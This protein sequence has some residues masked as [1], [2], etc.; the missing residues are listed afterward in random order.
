M[1]LLH[2]RYL[3]PLIWHLI[4]PILDLVLLEVANATAWEIA[5]IEVAI[6]GVAV[7]ICVLVVVTLSIPLVVLAVCVCI[8]ITFLLA[9]VRIVA[10]IPALMAIYVLLLIVSLSPVTGVVVPLEV[11]TRVTGEAIS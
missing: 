8:S 5:L 3:L 10:P 4:A 6:A 2:R 7:L 9:I 11:A 1:F